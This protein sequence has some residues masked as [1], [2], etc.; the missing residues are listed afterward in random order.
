MKNTNMEFN[1]ESMASLNK[2]LKARE[3]TGQMPETMPTGLKIET[4]KYN[5][6]EYGS[7]YCS[8][9]SD[10][11]QCECPYDCHECDCPD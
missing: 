1:P 6:G 9:C 8:V 4:K 11:E 2:L 10:C 5:G 3:I 7:D